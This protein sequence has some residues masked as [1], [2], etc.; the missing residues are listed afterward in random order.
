M[1]NKFLDVSGSMTGEMRNGAF[2]KVSSR[3]AFVEK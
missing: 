2:I 3:M 1:A